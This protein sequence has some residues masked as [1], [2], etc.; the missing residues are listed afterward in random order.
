MKIR[1]WHL[2][3]LAIVVFFLDFFTLGNRTVI[4]NPITNKIAVVIALLCV[5]ALLFGVIKAIHDFLANLTKDKKAQKISREQEVGQ[6]IR[7][8]GLEIGFRRFL[9]ILLILFAVPL[10]ILLPVFGL[11]LDLPN[12]LLALYLLF[13]RRYHLIF[14][15]LLA[16]LGCLFYFVALSPFLG[17]SYFSLYRSIELSVCPG[18]INPFIAF[19]RAAGPLALTK[20]FFLTASLFLFMGDIIARLKLAHKRRLNAISFIIICLVL[21]FLPY[22]YIPH[23]ALGEAHSGGTGSLSG[24]DPSHFSTNNTSYQMAFDQALNTYT[25][26][27]KMPNQDSSNPAFITTICVDGKIIPL[28]VENSMLEVENGV[29]ADGRISVA[30]NQTAIIKLVSQKPFYVVTLFEG[31]FYY[32]TNFIK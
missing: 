14:D 8:G 31:K 19:I 29:V 13:N 18:S 27:A 21:L 22:L 32:G 11:I 10:G 20:Y 26:S 5:L 24:F 23:V 3:V 17:P 7:A 4:D 12:L 30:P 9:A 6:G 1:S 16:S 28:T 2:I 15:C 25:F